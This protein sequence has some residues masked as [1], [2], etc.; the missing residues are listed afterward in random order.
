[1]ALLERIQ[2]SD[3]E[4]GEDNEVLCVLGVAPDCAT[5]GHTSQS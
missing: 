3:E 1:M 4:D 2:S 5:L